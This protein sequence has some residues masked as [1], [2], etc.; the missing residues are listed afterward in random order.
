[1]AQEPAAAVDGHNVEAKAMLMRS[2][3]MVLERARRL[4]LPSRR[5]SSAHHSFTAEFDGN[6]PVPSRARS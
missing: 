2:R 3:L 5:R 4:L 6:R 1:M